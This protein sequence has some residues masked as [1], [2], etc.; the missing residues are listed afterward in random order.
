MWKSASESDAAEARTSTQSSWRR[1]DGVGV[2]IVSRA[3]KDV[4]ATFD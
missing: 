3:G 4:V 2:I 1:V